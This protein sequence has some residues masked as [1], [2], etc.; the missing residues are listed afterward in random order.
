M[1]VLSLPS[2]SITYRAAMLHT[3]SSD[4]YV[5]TYIRITDTLLINTDT[6]LQKLVKKALIVDI[7]NILQMRALV[8]DSSLLL[9]LTLTCKQDQCI[10]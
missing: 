10:W 9:H 5:I 7:S 2:P 1:P 3:E 6:A 8:G 4:F